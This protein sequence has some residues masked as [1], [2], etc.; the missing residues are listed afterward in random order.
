[1]ILYINGD[2]HSAAAMAT[3]DFVCSEDDVDLWWMG[4]ASHPENLKVCFGAYISSVLKARL[5]NEADANNTN[6][7][8]IEQTKK[9][10]ENNPVNE[11]VVAIIGVPD[12][13]SQDLLELAGFLKKHEVK[14]ILYPI[15]D[16]TNW[17]EINKFTPNEFGYFDSLAHKAWAG[18]LIKPLTKI[19]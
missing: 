7:T 4:R 16:Y 2:G 9:F 15:T 3:N 14:H 5:V 13:N 11:Q 12:Y 19:L 8:I 1:M 6:Q 10:I 17:L 18:Y